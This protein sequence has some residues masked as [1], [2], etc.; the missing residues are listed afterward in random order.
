[1]ASFFSKPLACG[2]LLP[3]SVSTSWLP[4]L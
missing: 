2:S 4:R 3:M 1:L